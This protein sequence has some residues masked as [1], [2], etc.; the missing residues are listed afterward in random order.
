MCIG[1]RSGD[2]KGVNAE[3]EQQRAA[4]EATFRETNERIREVQAEL[5]FTRRLVPFLCECG[6]VTAETDLR[7]EGT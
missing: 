1:C 5:E 6:L 7:A 2:S 4:D 3:D